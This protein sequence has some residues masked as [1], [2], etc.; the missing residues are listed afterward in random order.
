M[1]HNKCFFNQNERTNFDMNKVVQ[2]EIILALWLYHKICYAANVK[3][4][5]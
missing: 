3:V 5:T 1:W 2:T 4:L